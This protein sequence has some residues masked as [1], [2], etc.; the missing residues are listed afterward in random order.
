MHVHDSAPPRGDEGGDNM[1]MKPARATRSTRASVKRERDL[2]LGLRWI[3][4]EIAHVARGN[5]EP[6]ARSAAKA[7]L[8]S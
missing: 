2:G 6:P 3:P 5:P 8:R 7:A 4:F 1:R